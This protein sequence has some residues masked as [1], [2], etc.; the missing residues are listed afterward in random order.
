MHKKSYPDGHA[1]ASWN[2]SNVIFCVYMCGVTPPQRNLHS[3]MTRATVS[4]PS[5]KLSLLK[6]Y[7]KA[8]QTPQGIATSKSVDGCT[9]FGFTSVV[10]GNHFIP[11]VAII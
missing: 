4:L 8:V 7:V 9:Q 6:S 3:K 11:K 1:D 5:T 2:E 10:I